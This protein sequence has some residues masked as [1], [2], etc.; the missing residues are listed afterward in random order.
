MHGI[1]GLSWLTLAI[2]VLEDSVPGGDVPEVLR[3]SLH[4]LANAAH[5]DKGGKICLQNGCPPPQ[6]PPRFALMGELMLSQAARNRVQWSPNSGTRG[7]K[8]GLCV[9]PSTLP[10]IIFWAS[11]GSIY[12][13]FS[14]TFSS[15]AWLPATCVA[16]KGSA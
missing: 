6:P 9:M 1:S 16:S 13:S 5:M 8:C 7:V 3:Q 10:A 12:P 11:Y 4:A 2:G 15:P 14:I